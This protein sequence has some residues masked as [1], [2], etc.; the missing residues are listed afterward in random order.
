VFCVWGWCFVFGRGSEM[1][2]ELF[3]LIGFVSFIVV[4]IFTVFIH[5]R[6]FD[7]VGDVIWFF[8]FSLIPGLN[9]VIAVVFG[10]FNIMFCVELIRRM[11]DF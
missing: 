5:R 3:W 10:I 1:T 2:F 6:N 4:N 7:G 11:Y 9:L 8:G